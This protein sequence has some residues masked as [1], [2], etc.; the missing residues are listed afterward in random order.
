M[1][2][3]MDNLINGRLVRIITDVKATHAN[4]PSLSKSALVTSYKFNV[5]FLIPLCHLFY[6][7]DGWVITVGLLDSF[8]IVLVMPL[9]ALQ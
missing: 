5:Y 2:T 1:Y 9:A 7:N 6:T 8:V 4:S 3:E